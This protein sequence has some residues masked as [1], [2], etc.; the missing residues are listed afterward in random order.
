LPIRIYALAKQLNLDS[1]SLVDICA[2]AGVSGKGSALASLSDEEVDKIKAFLASDSSE[3]PAAKK[4]PSD[5]PLGRRRGKRSAPAQPEQP[6]PVRRE[7]Y[8]A[9]TAATNDKIRVISE[10]RHR[11][12]PRPAKE[13][14]AAAAPEV[15]EVIEPAASTETPPEPAP[16]EPA[17]PA[18]EKPVE[19]KEVP[20][21]TPVEIPER[22]AEE[23]AAPTEPVKEKPAAKPELIGSAEDTL[24]TSGTLG[25]YSKS[26]GSVREAPGQLYGGGKR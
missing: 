4:P 14:P 7:D 23:K 24:F 10:P 15:P 1:K 26:L 13:E 2:Q 20:A 17:P 12:T 19:P 22:P 8:I 6:A 21:A 5:T 16:S 11:E 18:V 9:P 3:K 25:R